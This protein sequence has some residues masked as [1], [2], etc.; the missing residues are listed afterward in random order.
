MIPHPKSGQS[1]SD[2]F[3]NRSE[4]MLLDRSKVSFDGTECDKVS[5]TH[6]SFSRVRKTGGCAAR[7]T[8]NEVKRRENGLRRRMLC[9]MRKHNAIQYIQSGQG[10]SQRQG[11]TEEVLTWKSM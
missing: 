7:D 8:Q 10:E 4:W 6:C 3:A 5:S 9:H 2:V 11:R 1:V